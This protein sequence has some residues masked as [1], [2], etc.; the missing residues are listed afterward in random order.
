MTFYVGSVKACGTPA[1]T[2][3]SWAKRKRR[4]PQKPKVETRKTIARRAKRRAGQA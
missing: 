2:S 4:K 3:K 1:G